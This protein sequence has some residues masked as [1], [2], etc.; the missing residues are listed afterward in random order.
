MKNKNTIPNKS[1]AK[2]DKKLSDVDIPDVDRPVPKRGPEDV[3]EELQVVDK[4]NIN[5]S[6]H[7]HS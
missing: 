7:T 3:P 6:L 4:T 5:K 1:T 2:P